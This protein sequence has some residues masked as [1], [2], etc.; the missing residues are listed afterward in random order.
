[1]WTTAALLERHKLGRARFNWEEVWNDDTALKPG[2]R[3]WKVCSS[4]VWVWWMRRAATTR[5]HIGWGAPFARKLVGGQTPRKER[6]NGGY[7]QKKYSWQESVGGQTP[8]KKRLR[9]NQA[10]GLPILSG[11]LSQFFPIV[12]IFLKP[13]SSSIPRKKQIW[14]R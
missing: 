1:M 12:W 14:G 11:P 4:S 7:W 5:H 10:W 3:G 6:L 2:G 9:K 8:R 13:I